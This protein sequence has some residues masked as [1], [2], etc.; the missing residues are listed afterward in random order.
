MPNTD[1]AMYVA[2]AS[3]ADRPLHRI[4]TSPLIR[5]VETAL[6]ACADVTTVDGVDTDRPTIRRVITERHTGSLCDS[7]S[8]LAKLQTRF[9]TL[10]FSD[11][12]HPT[13]W[14]YTN[15]QAAAQSIQ[16]RGGIMEFLDAER[17]IGSPHGE[18]K[19]GWGVEPGGPYEDSRVF[20]EHI[21]S[22]C[23]AITEYL[24]SLPASEERVAVFA[25]G[26]ILRYLLG[27]DF[28]NCEVAEFQWPPKGDLPFAPSLVFLDGTSVPKAEGANDAARAEC[29]AS[30]AD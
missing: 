7:G 20:R 27:R 24:N 5:A 13:D 23:L 4:I 19:P 14:W 22:R 3:C 28:R 30:I 21:I 6:I 2:S 15:E 1:T 18:P 11:L 25:H 17:P 16:K 12:S 10:D 8:P 9:K 29:A 26:G